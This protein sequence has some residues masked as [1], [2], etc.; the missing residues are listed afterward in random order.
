[1]H[2]HFIRK[3][4]N[5]ISKK[6]AKEFLGLFAINE[7]NPNARTKALAY[8]NQFEKFEKNSIY[9]D[10]ALFYTNKLSQE[11]LMNRIHI[12]VHLN[13]LKENYNQIIN[14]I[15]TFDQTKLLN[16]VLV[17]KSYENADAWLCYRVGEAY[18]YRS[19][20]INAEKFYARAYS[21][22]PFYPDFLNKYGSVCLNNNN[23]KKARELFE[24]LVKEFPNFAPGY[25]N[26]GYFY[27]M[28]ENIEPAL[29]YFEKA[30][31]LD[32]DYELALMNK[33]SVMMY[34]NKTKDAKDILK[35]IISKNPNQEKAKQALLQLN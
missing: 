15:E 1:V 10:S 29:S 5:K 22:A 19:D 34:Q 31:L 26:L 11:S 25:S 14:D 16:Q 13:F 30:L 17:K 9:L 33:A 28:E 32:P 18:Q 7:V 20:F 27:L 2:D 24:T 8:L 3:P 12:L 6:Q 23:R 35:H 4:Q 21:L